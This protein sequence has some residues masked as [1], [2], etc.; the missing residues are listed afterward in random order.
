MQMIIRKHVVGTVD[1]FTDKQY[2]THYYHQSIGY[3]VTRAQHKK[4]CKFYYLYN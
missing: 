2:L 4:N 3:N 1:G